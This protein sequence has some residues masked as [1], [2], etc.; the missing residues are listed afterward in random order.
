MGRTKNH[1][2]QPPALFPSNAIQSLFCVSSS[3]LR[4][5][6]LRWATPRWRR[7]WWEPWTLST[8]WSSVAWDGASAATLPPGGHCWHCGKKQVLG[9]RFAETEPRYG[10][11][12]ARATAASAENYWAW[13]RGSCDQSLCLQVTGTPA[14]WALGRKGVTAPGPPA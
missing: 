11:E 4:T 13:Y 5:K 6:A 3:Q 2:K 14:T 1:H 7:P 12:L 9:S 8:T 10:Q